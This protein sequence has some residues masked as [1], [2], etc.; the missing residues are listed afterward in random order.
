MYNWY[1]VQHPFTKLAIIIAGFY[2]YNKI[3]TILANYS[4]SVGG[5]I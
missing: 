3:I 2:A 5:I 1:K 4:H